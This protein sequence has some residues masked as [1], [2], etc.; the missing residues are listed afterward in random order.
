M[1]GA[2]P[3]G[4]FTRSERAAIFVN[5]VLICVLG[6][7]VAAGVTALVADLSY[8]T[9]LR[10]DLTASG[11]FSLD[12]GAAAIVDGVDEPVRVTL[13]VGM[14]PDRR[15]RILDLSGAPRMDL[16]DRHYRPLLLEYMVR[17]GTVLE[18]WARRNAKIRIDVIEKDSDL[19][20]LKAAAEF[21]GKSGDDLV[22][23]VTLR[24]GTRER[25]VPL[26]W[27]ARAEWG[28]FPPDPRRPAVFPEILGPWQVQSVLASTLRA[29]AEGETTRV[30]IPRGAKS[31]LEP[32]A[33]EFAPVA[34][35]LKSNGYEPVPFALKD[36]VPDDCGI[37]LVPALSGS[38]GAVASEKLREFEAR[39]GRI[40]LLA[41]WS[42]PES[43]VPILEPYG[44]RLPSVVV[45]DPPNKRAGQPDTFLLES[46]R[47][48]V[49][50]HP[51]DSGL[52]DR[53]TLY[54]GSVRPVVVDD[55]I[56]GQG[57]QRVP[58]LRG[59]SDAKSAPVDY[60]ST[61]GRVAPDLAN[62]TATPAPLY[63]AALSRPGVGGRECRVVVV[64]T[65]EL[66]LPELLT[67]G[68][69]WGN[70]DFVL[71]AFNWLSE[72]TVALSNVADRDLRGARIEVTDSVLDVFHLV[73][74]ISIPV[75]LLVCGFVIAARRRR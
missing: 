56:R 45:E 54:L 11:R 62:R 67:I 31:S 15:A 53:T 25:V 48:A 3:K 18:E 40:L 39:S 59:S 27:M 21:H 70:R 57:V 46:S 71:N 28:F 2:D 64:G 66:F 6:A 14:D 30:A 72:R 47:L 37:L 49:G 23:K 41:D 75:L 73:A 55:K 9:P 7:A 36:G 32:D 42:R 58:L 34:R 35:F 43:Y 8:R 51:I 68:G 38:L 74:T 22:N 69:N 10:A 63:A 52:K 44:V 65:P 5:V 1:N 20:R 24:C 61:D 33:P 16:Y 26:D 12:P 17:V 60:G 19:A 29:V 13:V 4:S 50:L